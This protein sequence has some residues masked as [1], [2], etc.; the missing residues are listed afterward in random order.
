MMCFFEEIGNMKINLLVS[1]NNIVE[2][3]LNK[4]KGDKENLIWM[5]QEDAVQLEI[6]TDKEAKNIIKITKSANV[7]DDDDTIKQ[8]FLDLVF[9]LK[10]NRLIN[11]EDGFDDAEEGEEE[12]NIMKPYD[13]K[14]IRVDTKTFSIEQINQM[15]NDGDIDLSP[16]FQRGF[17]WT[18]I[19]RKSRLIESLLLRIPIPVFYFSQDE[20]GVFQVVDGVQRLTVINSFMN[21]KF[22]LKNLE[23]LKEC[24]NKWYKKNDDK[25][26]NL[27]SMFRRRIQQTQ[28]Y[29]NV[30][31]PQT[32]GKVKYDIFKRI[33]TGGKALTNQEIRNC[34][35]N[36]RTRELLRDLAKSKNF[37]VATRGSIS[38]TRMA[39]E[40]LILRFIS[41][42]LID[43]NKT[44]TKEYK[45][46]M[47]SLLD[48]TIEFLNS[49]DMELMKEIRG[50]F[51]VAMDNAYYLFGDNAF[52]KAN[53]INKS[54]FL[55]V[56]RVLSKYTREEIAAKK[57]KEISDKLN[58]K[59]KNN[60]K[61]T[62]ALSMATNDAK[63]VKIVFDT[64]A[65]LIGE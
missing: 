9:E 45:G 46:G 16:D 41:F 29:V 60:V 21:D 6:I 47:D 42:Y 1:E 36:S 58:D 38:P 64:V 39:D 57:A 63:N 27:D 12:Q 31:D 54:L 23:Y 40:E 5:S 22:K 13:P 49:A 30:I 35:A 18:D 7:K 51:F 44:Q 28:I 34:L 62:N 50:A 2:I 33:N 19:T 25:N 8:K 10:I 61:F 24:N 20:Q 52:R 26:D 65:Q 56:S 37:M 4:Q 11:D 17:V 15:I 32:P 3:Q 48:E 59:I 55:G 14:L 43:N 53:Y